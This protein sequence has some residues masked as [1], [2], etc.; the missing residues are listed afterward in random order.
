MTTDAEARQ[1]L[2]HRIRARRA[3]ITAYVRDLEPR[4]ARLMAISIICSAL[5]A[6]LTA[7]PALGGTRFTDAV[8]DMASLSGGS[9]VWRT[10]CLAALVLSIVAAVTTNLYRSRD[11]GARLG[12]AEAAGAALEGLEALVE[13]GRLPLEDAVGLYQRAVADIPFVPDPLPSAPPA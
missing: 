1:Q 12:K 4:G 6:A 13:F 10:L 3:S 2:V 7:G 11:V 8:Q 5:V 9:V